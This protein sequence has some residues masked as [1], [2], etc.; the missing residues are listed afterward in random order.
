[1]VRLR[2]IID[3]FWDDLFINYWQFSIFLSSWASCQGRV[4]RLWNRHMAIRSYGVYMVSVPILTF[5][6]N[7]WSRLPLVRISS[8][9]A[10]HDGVFSQWLESKVQTWAILCISNISCWY[11]CNWRLPKP[12]SCLKYS[13]IIHCLSLYVCM[14]RLSGTSPFLGRNQEKTI[15]NIT[16]MKYPISSLYPNVSPEAKAF[17]QAI[18]KEKPM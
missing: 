11:F 18:F 8:A 13:M 12:S 16:R 3:V 2:L 1:M 17:L 6:K 10:S 4:D 14:I 15:Y 5:S 9:I 7:K